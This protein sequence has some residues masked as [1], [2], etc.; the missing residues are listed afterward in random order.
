[1]PSKNSET[2][3]RAEAAFRSAFS[4]L[5]LDE[6]VILPKGSAVSQNN[7]AREA[8]LDPSA[9]KKARFPSLVAEIQNWSSNRPSPT[10]ASSRQMI[11]SQKNRNH[12][13]LQKIELL[14]IQR[15]KALS[16]LAEADAYILEL[17]QK[18]SKLESKQPQSN[19]TPFRSS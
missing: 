3:S 9:L 2:S 5:K 8:G 1:M 14:K 18:L 15:D 7:V 10:K 6:P 11:K 12:Q 17:N 4:R 13:L 16:L 19:V